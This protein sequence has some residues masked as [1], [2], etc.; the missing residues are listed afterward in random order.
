MRV[1]LQAFQLNSSS[2]NISWLTYLALSA[3]VTKQIEESSLCIH[4]NTRGLM[5]ISLSLFGIG[6]M[7]EWKAQVHCC[8]RGILPE[9]PVYHL[10]SQK[11]NECVCSALSS[12]A[13]QAP[14][15]KQEILPHEQ[16]SWMWR[17]EVRSWSSSVPGTPAPAVSHDPS[18][19]ASQILPEISSLLR[20]SADLSNCSMCS[21][22]F[23]NL[24]WLLLSSPS[25]PGL[26]PGDLC[27]L[28]PLAGYM[29]FDGR[30]FGPWCTQIFFLRGILLFILFFKVLFIYF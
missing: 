21:L 16:F 19:L 20:A 11:K 30:L 6:K 10:R 5:R 7:G 1:A 26:P 23:L 29:T 28:Q 25:F 27:A 22:S 13:L 2:R 15:T 24:H 8:P 9:V 14:T 3:A 4:Q 17:P 18:L 12:F